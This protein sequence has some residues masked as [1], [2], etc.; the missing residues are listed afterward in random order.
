MPGTKRVVVTL[1]VPED[2]DIYSIHEALDAYGIEGIEFDG[3]A[4][5]WESV[6]AFIEDQEGDTTPEQ[7]EAYLRSL[8]IDPEKLTRF[9]PTRKG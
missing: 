5:V 1:D 2:T 4:I 7:A 9:N 3:E 6:E 8:G